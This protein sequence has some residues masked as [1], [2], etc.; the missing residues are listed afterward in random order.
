MNKSPKEK[1]RRVQNDIQRG[2]LRGYPK[3]ERRSCPGDAVVR[4]LAANP[5]S[6]TSEDETDEQGAWYH[7][8]HCSPCSF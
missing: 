8:M 7:I 2:I 6:I 3:P 4:N 1:Y 5:G